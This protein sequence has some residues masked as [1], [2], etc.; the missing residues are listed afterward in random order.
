MELKEDW[1]TYTFIR[2]LV[3]LGRLIHESTIDERAGERDMGVLV[4][5]KQGGPVEG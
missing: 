4:L 1:K 5:E 2:L 3:G